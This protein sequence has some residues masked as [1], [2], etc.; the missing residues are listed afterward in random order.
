[1]TPRFDVTTIGETMLRL[2]VPIGARLSAMHT[3]E[4]EI[5]GAESNVCVALARLGELYELRGD[6]VQAVQFN[7]RFL[8]LWRDADPDFRPVLDRVRE[9]QRRLTAERPAAR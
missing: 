2:S 8:E 4:A 3:L 9:R 1:M 7:A 6:T 5:G